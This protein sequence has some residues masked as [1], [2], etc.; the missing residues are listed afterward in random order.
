[1]TTAEVSSLSGVSVRTLHYYDEIGLLS[2]MRESENSYRNYREEDLD[3]LQQILLFRACGFSL[4]QIKE[5]LYSADFNREQAFFMQRGYLLEERNRLDVMLNTL[6][7]SIQHM[8]GEINMNTQDKFQGFD[9]SDDSYREEVIER[10][11]KEGEHSLQQMKQKSESDKHLFSQEMN[12]FFQEFSQKMDK[13]YD[14]LELQEK[15]KEFHEYLNKN[16]GYHYSFEAFEGLG[17]M[18]SEDSRFRSNI[19]RYAVGLASFLCDAMSYYAQSQK[20]LAEAR[21]DR[22][23]R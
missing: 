23:C 4:A 22:D 12:D 20:E 21:N 15:V 13:P 11:G 8:R 10:W 14:D 17:Q 1:M 3:Q 18:Y 2:P 5:I 9:F 6:E 19:D 7:Q 16:V